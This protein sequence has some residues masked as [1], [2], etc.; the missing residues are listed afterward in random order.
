MEALYQY[1]WLIPL[2][3]LLGA[4]V[5]GLGLISYSQATS[6]LRRGSAIFIV[7]LLGTAMVLSFGI[8]WSQ[9][10]GHETYTQMFEWAAAGD[11]KLS[12]GYTIDH[13]TA[14]MLV[15]VTTVAFL[16]MVYT[17]GYMAHDAGYVRFYAYLS[18]FSSS[19]LGLVVSPNLVQVYIFWELVGVSSYLLIGFWYDRKAAADACQKA[20]VTNRVGDFGL[21]LGM[22]GIY[23]AT[24]SF[25]F[26][27]M[28]VR[29]EQLVETGAL[30]AGLATLFGV[31]VFLG[32]A[33][34]SAQFPLHVWLPDAMEGP[35]P[36]SALIH[37]ATMVAAGVFLVARMYPV[38]EHLPIV[39]NIIAWTGAFTAFLGATIAITQNDIKKGLAYS[40]ISQLGYMVM[41]MGVGAYSAGLFHLM[42]HA[43]FKAMLFLC[44][45]SVIHGMEAVVGHNPVLAQDMRLMGGLRKYMPVTSACFLIGTLAICGIPPFAGFWSKDEILGSAFG[46]NPALWLIGWATAGMTAFYMFRMYFSTFEGE[47]RG[48]D[49]QIKQQLMAANSTGDKVEMTPAVAFG[50]GAMDPKELEHGHDDHDHDHDHGHHSD[51][52][53]E[54]P[55]SMTLPLMV[56]AIPSMI[57]GLLGTPFANYFEQFIYAP[58]ESL[59]QVLEELA[60]FDLTEFL[61]MAGNSVGIA[62]IGITFASL[63]YLSRKIDPSAIAEKIKPL[64]NFSLNKWYLD[65]LNDFLFVKG[66]RRLARQ[67]L[68]VDYKVVDG[69]VNLTGFITLLTGEGLKYLENGRA[70]FY[71]LIVFVAVLGLV[72][73]SGV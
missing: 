33:A 19:M 55:I 7:S 66:S 69:A 30:S 9:I 43:Y 8:L 23:W 44:S 5:V 40:T 34:K 1:A 11:F 47:F 18:L 10:N 15:I 27:V 64:Y 14:L 21:L 67:V 22:L 36:I 24:G 3:P 4:M 2:L 17:D 45:G 35:T 49:E 32:P 46:A 28:G 71:A 29:L 63:M 12:M 48:N 31:L 42:T 39:M 59:A 41:A 52:P 56:L 61:I 72:V 54:S 38:F 6:N 50:P 68:E 70:Q 37:A 57:I 65:D 62:L 25:E 51:S 13:L 58:G 26:E 60:E 73:F 20:F 53:H 16:V